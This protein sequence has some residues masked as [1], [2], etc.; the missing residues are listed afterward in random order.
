MARPASRA[1]LPRVKYGR[2]DMMVTE[3]CAGT[4]TWGSFNAEEA[5]AHAQ[6]DAFWDAGVNFYDT[7]ELYPVAFNYGKT[8][9]TW[10]GRW[11][12]KKL[13]AGDMKRAD[14]YLATKCNP[15]GV[16]NKGEKHAFDAETLRSSCENSIER[17]QCAYID[18]YMLHF[19]S[20]MCSEAFGWGSWVSWDRYK[21]AASSDGS[22]EDFERQVLAVKELLDAGL[23]KHWGLSNETAYGVTMFCTACDKLGVPRPVSIQNDFNY[24]NRVFEGDVAEACHHFGV[25]GMPYGALAGGALT[26][27]LHSAKYAGDRPLAETRHKKTPDFQ[28]R[29]CSPVGMDACGAYIA[30][31][32]KWGLTPCEMALCWSRDRGYNAVVVTGTT[33]VQ[34][35]LETVEAFKLE[36]LPRELNDAIDAIHEQ[37]RSPSVALASKPLVAAAPWRKG[38]WAPLAVGCMAA[39]AGALA[40]V[41]LRKGG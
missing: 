29:Y 12:A 31:A 20:R 7:A 22:R 24:N 28:P 23:I 1:A 40:A 9:E 8:T 15:N 35:C 38:A 14:I 3:L 18:L 36:P 25:V 26:G 13:E 34:Q 17:L 21:G 6:L 19:P 39:G 2:S 4:M 5:E 27:K 30:L 33:T 16:G 10:M 11:L 41:A 32:E 37:Y